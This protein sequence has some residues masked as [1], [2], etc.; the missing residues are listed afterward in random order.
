MRNGSTGKGTAVAVFVAVALCLAGC[1]ST[2]EA[3]DPGGQK[4]F[5]KYGFSLDY[6]DGYHVTEGGLLEAE[7]NDVSGML[8][9]KGG[10][11]GGS[12]FSLVWVTITAPPE[13]SEGWLESVEDDFFAG[14]RKAEAGARLEKSERIEAVETGYRVLYRCYALHYPGGA[15]ARG[16][17]G[18]FYCDEAGKLFILGTRSY[19]TA[20]RDE[21]LEE[22]RGYLDSLVCHAPDSQ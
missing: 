9:L 10:G 1:G 13:E 11:E 17:A 20:T 4:L 12:D 8:R 14:I 5:S 15:V 2:G 18:S 6:P 22:F 21:L 16:V 19:R 7:A 3:P